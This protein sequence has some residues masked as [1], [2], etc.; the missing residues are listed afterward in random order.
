V[1]GSQR[2]EPTD[3]AARPAHKVLKFLAMNFPSGDIQTEELAA[4]PF[5]N[6]FAAGGE[7]VSGEV[8]HHSLIC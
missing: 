6:Y 7:R 5:C 3:G 1:R 4:D 8:R 2:P